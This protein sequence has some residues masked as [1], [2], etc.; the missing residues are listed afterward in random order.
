M[1]ISLASVFVFKSKHIS[2]LIL[3]QFSTALSIT[4][5][6]VGKDEDLFKKIGKDIHMSCSVKE[7]YDSLKHILDIVIVG[8]LEKR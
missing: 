7:C 4:A 3:Y 6:F 2:V 8:E 5:D 1:D